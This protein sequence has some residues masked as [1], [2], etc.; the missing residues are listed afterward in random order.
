MPIDNSSAFFSFMI[1][2][3]CGSKDDEVRIPAVMPIAPVNSKYIDFN[4]L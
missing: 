1:F 4:L 2:I 3:N